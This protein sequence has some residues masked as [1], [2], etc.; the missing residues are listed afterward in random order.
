VKFQNQLKGSTT[1]INSHP[2]QEMKSWCSIADDESNE[3]VLKETVKLGGDLNGRQHSWP[4]NTERVSASRGP[5]GLAEGLRKGKAQSEAV[6]SEEDRRL[7]LNWKEPL[8]FLRKARKYGAAH[9]DV[10][11]SRQVP[12][13]SKNFKKNRKKKSLIVKVPPPPLKEEKERTS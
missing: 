2:Y 6:A 7:R 1:S 4:A 12:L 13:K 10:L 5:L 3:Q 9:R 11:R 8:R